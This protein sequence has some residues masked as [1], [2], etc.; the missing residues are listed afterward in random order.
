MSE[1]SQIMIGYDDIRNETEYNFTNIESE[2]RREYDF[3]N[4]DVRIDDPVGIAVSDNGHRLVDSSGICHYVGFSH[5]G[6]YFNWKP[7]DGEPH[8]VK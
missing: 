5:G 6:F 4:V 7:Y 1:N 3:G 8:F 2:K